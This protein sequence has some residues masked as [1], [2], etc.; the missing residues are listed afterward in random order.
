MLARL[1]EKARRPVEQLRRTEWKA[2]IN[3]HAQLKEQAGRL[4]AQA[5]LVERQKPRLARAHLMIG[6]LSTRSE[7]VG[8]QKLRRGHAHPKEQAERLD[9]RSDLVGRQ[10]FLRA[11]ARPKGQAERLSVAGRSVERQNHP[12][13]HVRLEARPGCPVERAHLEKL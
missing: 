9:A 11:H 3:A 8:P 1:V 6:R 13:G 2:P 5:G 7:P 4:S 12:P 10:K